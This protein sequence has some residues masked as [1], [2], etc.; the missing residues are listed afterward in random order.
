MKRVFLGGA[1][2]T[3]SDDVMAGPPVELKH[4]VRYSPDGF[5]WGYGGSGPADLARSILGDILAQ[6]DPNPDDYQRVKWA[7]IATLPPEGGELTEDQVLEVLFD[8]LG[9][10]KTDED[11]YDALACP[12]SPNGRHC[13]HQDG[14]IY[15]DKVRLTCCHCGDDVAITYVEKKAGVP[16][17]GPFLSEEFD[18]TD[19]ENLP[20]LWD[21]GDGVMT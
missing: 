14:L 16:G 1:V 15:D 6:T 13:G 5:E 2:V 3:V 20:D 4:L 21:L 17:H 7:L 10:L 8:R 11:A 18:A 9:E 19:Y 12:E